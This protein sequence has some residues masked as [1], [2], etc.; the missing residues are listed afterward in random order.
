MSYNTT[1]IEK[2]FRGHT[3]AVFANPPLPPL[4]GPLWEAS[5]LPPHSFNCPSMNAVRR[6]TKWAT[7]TITASTYCPR[8]FFPL[9]LGLPDSLEIF[10]V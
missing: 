10:I 4:N 3:M 1:I 5:E 8:N 9:T 2:I 7:V 6:E